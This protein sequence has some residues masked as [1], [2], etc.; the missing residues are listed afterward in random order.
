MQAH[1]WWVK[2]LLTGEEQIKHASS[3]PL[4]QHPNLI[5]SQMQCDC[6]GT[7][8]PELQPLESLWV[9]GSKTFLPAVEPAPTCEPGLSFLSKLPL[10]KRVS[11]LQHAL[12]LSCFCSFLELPPHFFLLNVP[13]Q[14]PSCRLQQVSTCLLLYLHPFL[15]DMYACRSETLEASSGAGVIVHSFPCSQGPGY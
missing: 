9:Q 13:C 1:M 3:W 7:C 8:I 12:L 2:V 11:V 4:G 10:V 6:F 14:P 5:F 15:S